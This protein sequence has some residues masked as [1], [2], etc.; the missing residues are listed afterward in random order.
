MTAPASSAV[1]AVIL[2]HDGEAI[3]LEEA[4]A[5]A[6]AGPVRD[7]LKAA[8]SWA[9]VAWS[10]RFGKPAGLRSGEQFDAYTAE[11][12][13][14]IRA[15]GIDPVAVL[16]D[17]AQRARVLG[18]D[19]GLIEAGA[20][21]IDL[22]SDVR[23]ETRRHIDE[24]VGTARAKIA[25][26]ADLVEGLE[27]GS[28][29]TI[30][31]QL[32]V[33]DQAGNIVERTA[34]TVT[35]DELNEGLAA[36]ADH[37]GGRLV[38]IAERDACVMCLALSGHVIEPGDAFDWRLTFGAKA[39]PPKDYNAAGELVEIELERP[40]RHPYCRC[41][42]SPWL[43]HDEAAARAVTHDWAEAIKEADAKGDTVAADAARRAAAA[44]RDSAA[45]DLP[46][47]L[48]REAERS[49]LN[50]YAL[51]S[52]SERIRVQ[53]ADRLLARIGAGKNSRSP[54]GWQVPASVK[55]R[56]ERALKKGTFSTRSVPTGRK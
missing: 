18:A 44:A 9:H 38:W 20:P 5:T 45:F 1:P 19:Q 24:A 54:S 36:A 42:V 28:F 48:R 15:V 29:K 7:A 39:Y 8:L 55:K 47:A 46:A 17:F 34:R 31:R 13:A 3:S 30:N 23:E 53:A 43:G 51:P 22:G 37:V 25:E 32:A 12:A 4:A 11:L 26:A 41:R 35:N 52:E 21:R 49:I 40:P 14:R 6:A 50:G 2:A 27:R 16:L 33:A 10:K 56:A